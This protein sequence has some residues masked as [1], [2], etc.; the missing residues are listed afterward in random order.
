MLYFSYGS[1]MSS[2]RLKARVPSA[3]FVAKAALHKHDLRFHKISKDGSGKCD[4]YET[5]K[6]E[7]A[8]IGVV[9]EMTDTEK[10]DL[11]RVEGIGYGYLDKI[12]KLT[13]YSGETIEAITYYAKEIDSKLKPYHWYKY[14]VLT[15]ATENALPKGYVE[16]IG[17]I[18]SIA[19]PKLER[20]ESEMVIYANK[21]LQPTPESIAARRGLQGWPRG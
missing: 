8:V 5:G 19:D 3:T 9:F 20:H 15:G 14:H 10:T 12:V 13:T 4:A 18:E 17:T 6:I 16:Q 21:A 11:D 2:K 1:N 7:H